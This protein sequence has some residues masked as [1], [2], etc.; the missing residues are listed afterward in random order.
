MSFNRPRNLYS[1]R[2]CGLGHDSL[3]SLLKPISISTKTI[4]DRVSYAS[5]KRRT[6]DFNDVNQKCY[7][8]VDME[9]NDRYA[10]DRLPSMGRYL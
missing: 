1:S 3:F 8:I 6:S 9:T 10:I 4:H 7:K 5:P 2:P